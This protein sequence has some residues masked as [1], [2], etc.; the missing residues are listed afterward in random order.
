MINI[1]HHL[2]VGTMIKDKFV[3]LDAYSEID[4]KYLQI[5]DLLEDVT[6]TANYA[7]LMVCINGVMTNPIAE[8][9]KIKLKG[10]GYKWMLV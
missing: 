6:D 2:S 9:K 3:E 1:D 10:K 4:I 7:K 5:N 8:F